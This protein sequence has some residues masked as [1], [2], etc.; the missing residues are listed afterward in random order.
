MFSKGAAGDEPAPEPVE[1]REEPEA[2]AEPLK[3]ETPDERNCRYSLSHLE[4][5]RKSG[6]KHYV[7]RATYDL[8]TCPVCGA[9]DGKVFRVEDAEMGVNYPPMHPGC[10]CTTLPKLSKEAEEMMAPLLTM[11]R[12]T[13]KHYVVPR[14]FNYA[15]WYYFVGPGRDDGHEY[16]PYR[17]DT[18]PGYIPP[19]PDRVIE[20]VEGDP[21][22]WRKI[23]DE[24]IS[25]KAKSKRNTR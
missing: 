4:S 8:R 23:R 12:A 25:A 2:P 20:R 11:D 21:D 17:K 16:V 24:E 9:L 5:Y 15:D 19:R 3:E 7:F 13:R 14:D 1:T 6:V 22:A 10:R 18:G